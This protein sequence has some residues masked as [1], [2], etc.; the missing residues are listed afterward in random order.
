MVTAKQLA[1]IW[2]MIAF[3]VPYFLTAQ[4]P[5]KIHTSTLIFS[6]INNS[7]SKPDTISIS[8]PNSLRWNW[9]SGDSGCFKIQ[10]AETAS[11]KKRRWVVSF[12]PKQHLP[13]I[14]RATFQLINSSGRAVADFSLAGLV[15]KGLEG[16]NEAPLS[17]VVEALGYHIQVGWTGLA[18]H[19]RPELQGD[20]IP[21]SLFKKAGGGKIEMKP[22]A[23]FSPDFELPFGYYVNSSAGPQKKQ[24]GI[25]AKAGK[26]PEHQTL[27][28]ALA[29]GSTF[30]DPGN[31]TFWILCNWSHP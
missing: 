11:S 19:S 13:G 3:S 14:C 22:V 23:R 16:E 28:P 1:I 4:T 26:Y 8:S 5:V 24:A 2:M 17:S 18:N 25:L 6:A 30:F 29:S 10:L 21:F 9:N 20:E 31:E 27:F 7:V 15:T 12:E